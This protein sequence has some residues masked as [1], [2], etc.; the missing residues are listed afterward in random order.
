MAI[1]HIIPKHEWKARF[2]TLKGVNAS[3][4]LSPELYNEQHAQAH[5]FLYELNG[6]WKDYLAY[7]SLAKHIGKEEIRREL[8]RQMGLLNAG[9]KKG[10]DSPSHKKNLSESL[11]NSPAAIIQRKL[12]AESKRGKPAPRVSC[13]HCHKVGDAMNMKRWHKCQP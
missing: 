1:H 2:G 7:K 9:K 5:L 12:V 4:N 6:N 11:K 10:P 3:D 8:G 13:P